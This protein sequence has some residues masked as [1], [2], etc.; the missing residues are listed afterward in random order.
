MKPILRFLLVCFLL[1]A[2]ALATLGAGDPAT[3]FDKVGHTMMCVC[4]C[5][6]VLLECNHV[7]CQYSDKMRATLADMIRGGSSDDQIFQEFVQEYGTTVVAAPMGGG[8]N[9]FEVN[10]L[11]GPPAVEGGVAAGKAFHS[12]Y[13][14]VLGEHGYPG[15]ILYGGLILTSFAL[16]R[17]ASRRARGRPEMA[18]C[19]DLAS[20]LQVSLV[21]LLACGA[22]IGIAFQPMIF[23]VCALSAS[24][25]N[26]A[27]F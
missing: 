20:A 24:L 22:F 5:N 3:R 15:A 11:N 21:T 23:F 25:A 12:V 6:Q 7:G 10:G 16:L 1:L 9:A 18:A 26:Y 14:E 4:G 27:L 13:F 19:A 2:L 17:G 8:F